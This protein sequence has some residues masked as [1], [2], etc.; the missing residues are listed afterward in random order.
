MGRG[1]SDRATF[2]GALAYGSTGF[3]TSRRDSRRTD[4]F[5]ARFDAQ[6]FSGRL[7]GGYHMVSWMHSG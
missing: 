2:S 6:S 4:S 7:E 3:S 5:N 1:N